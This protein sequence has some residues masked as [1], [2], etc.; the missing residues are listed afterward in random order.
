M[1]KNL[2]Y[3]G[4][5]TL[6]L[7]SCGGSDEMPPVEEVNLPPSIPE[8][9][10]PTDNLLCIDNNLN[11][12]WN[13]STDSNGDAIIYQVEVSK[14]NEFSEIAHMADASSTAQAF[15]LEK[16]M[17]YYWRVKATDVLN[18]ASD[19]ST[20]F[21]LY[22]EGAAETNHLPFAPELVK[23]VLGSATQTTIVTLEWNA[24]D[25]DAN[26]SLTFDVYFGTEN[27][28]TTLAWENLTIKTLDVDVI[29]SH[30]YYW[31]VVVKDDSGGE[32]IGQIWNFRTN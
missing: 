20:T 24:S 21:S 9:V 29:V 4:T 28:P 7:W 23:P 17:A 16:N 6:L 12:Q 11:F 26:D 32:T 15:T 31:K 18:S 14:D 27:L 3:L 1:M 8:L 22:T 2:L 25:V 5:L 19:Y 30:D 13:A 10:Y